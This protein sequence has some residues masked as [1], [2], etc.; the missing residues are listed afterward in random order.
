MHCMRLLAV[1][2]FAVPALAQM[3]LR[4]ESVEAA[5]DQ[6]G[7]TAIQSEG[8]SVTRTLRD[9]W[10][11]T[12]DRETLTSNDAV[13]TV[14]ARPGHVRYHYRIRG[15]QVEVDYA[16]L[17]GRAFLTKQLTILQAPAPHYTLHRAEPLALQLDEA[18]VETRVPGANAP[19][20]GMTPEQTRAAL[21]PRDFGLFL[22]FG[23]T[24]AEG[25]MLLVQNPYLHAESNAHA[26]SLSYSPEMDWD[27]ASGPFHTDLAILGPD[28]LT[29]SLLPKEM[30]LEWRLSSPFDELSDGLDRGEAE[31]F[32]AAVR[33]FLIAPPS[34][35]SRVEVGWTLNDY[36][37][38]YGTSAGKAEYRRII[39][40]TAQLGITTLLY[41]AS[42][43]ALSSRDDDTDSWHW[44]HTLWLNLGQ[45]I[46]R[47]E[48]DPA[49]SPIP[50]DVT[51][52]IAYG[53]A[54]HVGILAY[55]YP[56]VPFAGNPAWLV[57]DAHLR[58]ATLASRAYQDL[59]IRD[60]LAFKRRTGIAV[61][62]LTTPF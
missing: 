18:P 11:L 8:S 22:R 29:G 21:P 57:A 40:S 43:T 38:E 33:A 2:L 52:L 19:Q 30:P 24:P 15:Y 56:S 16:L 13:P 26:A 31:A 12:I 17:P 44:E 25:L 35:P 55:V 32:T 45:K 62:L 1:L 37:V 4:N 47:G 7:V 53:R 48:W 59:L 27:A 60:L 28:R 20:L 41:A 10:S 23:R 50:L 58:Y 5:F 34:E 46:R 61:T 36:Q 54:K 6:R 3:H 14:E 39:D 49:T 51:E 9:G 42:N